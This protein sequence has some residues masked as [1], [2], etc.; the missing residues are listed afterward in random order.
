MTQLP[1][2]KNYLVPNIMRSEVR[3]PSLHINSQGIYVKASRTKWVQQVREYKVNI[4]I[5]IIVTYTRY[6]KELIVWVYG[7]FLLC[8]IHS[9][10]RIQDEVQKTSTFQVPGT[11][12]MFSHF[13]LLNFTQEKV[14]L[15]KYR[16][17]ITLLM[18][19]WLKLWINV[20]QTWKLQI[21]II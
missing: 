8:R 10:V 12:S 14:D 7:L 15:V 3:N 9:A 21:F 5:S 4:Q 11:L 20:F 13:N 17:Q 16:V 2:T 19:G 6:K 1:S 18:R